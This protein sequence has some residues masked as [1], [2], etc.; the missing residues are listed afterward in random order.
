[1]RIGGLRQKQRR[2]GQ[3]NICPIRIEDVP[4]RKNQTNHRSRSTQR[5]QLPHHVRQHS[6]RRARSQHDQQFILD[7][8]QKPENRKSRQPRNNSK[9]HHHKQ[10]ARQIKSTHQRQQISQRSHSITPHRER[11]SSKRPKR[12]RA[13][14]DPHNPEHHLVRYFNRAQRPL[15]HP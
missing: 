2:Q 13:H 4:R 12:R 7:I 10:K 14:H 11:H 15:S 8:R 3:I 5:F 1:M 6:F 9:D